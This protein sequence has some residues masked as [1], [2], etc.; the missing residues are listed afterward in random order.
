MEVIIPTAKVFTP[1]LKPSRYKG[2][3]GGRGSGKSHFLAERMI[4]DSVTSPGDYGAGLRSVCIREI[5]KTLKDS[6]KLLLEDKIRTH[7]PNEPFRI[8]NDAIITP[9]DGVITFNGMTDHNAESIKSLEGFQRAWIEEGQT[10]SA[11]SLELLRP[12]I[13]AEGSEIW[14]SW[15]PR[16]KQ[17]P[18]DAFFRGATPP[19]DSIVVKANWSDNPFFPKELEMERLHDLDHNPDRYH[20]VWEGDYITL[21]EGAYFAKGMSEAMSQGRITQVSRDPLMKVYAMWDIG[22]TGAKSDACSIWVIQYINNTCNVL[23]YYEAQGQDMPTHVNWLRKSGY[24]EAVCVLPHDG[25]TNDRVY[26]V[27]YESALNQAGFQVTVIP[28]QGRGAAMARVEEVRRM[29]PATWF[30]AKSTEGGREALCWYHE[31]QDEARG[32]GLGP[33]HD[34]SS[35]AADAFGLVAVFRNNIPTK[36]KKLEMNT[37]WIV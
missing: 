19:P 37:R 15:N 27:S 36:K 20:H 33:D 35:H 1:L 26:A 13:R 16:R 6:A 25:A 34:W 28:N 21:V 30:N 4:E 31:K 22:G 12:T 29:L 8:L 18:I 7:F 17:D 32:I 23:D 5:Q 2:V 9:G 14:A 10:L 24:A 3:W 11:R